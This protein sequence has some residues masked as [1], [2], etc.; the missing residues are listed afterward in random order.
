[1]L[2]SAFVRYVISKYGSAQAAQAAWRVIPR[3]V[4]N[5]IGNPGFEDAFD[6]TWL[7]SLSGNALAVVERDPLDKKEGNYSM[8]IRISKPGGVS[9]NVRYRNIQPQLQRY[10]LYRVQLWTRTDV[11]QR[12]ITVSIGNFSFSDTLRTQWKEYTYT[13]RSYIEG[14]AEFRVDAGGMP[15]DVWLDND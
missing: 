9:R 1:M 5:V 11:N 4:A 7:L 15:G 3:T 13:F 10:A 2:D 12:L 6:N 14:H 8:R